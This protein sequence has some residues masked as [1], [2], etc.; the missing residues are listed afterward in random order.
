[1]T[2]AS[3]ERKVAQMAKVSQVAK[4]SQ[5]MK[6]P[7]MT[8]VERMTKVAQ[9]TKVSEMTKVAQKTKVGRMPKASQKSSGQQVSRHGQHEAKKCA[10]QNLPLQRW[11]G[12]TP[13]LAVASRHSPVLCSTYSTPPPPSG[14]ARRVKPQSRIDSLASRA[15][16]RHAL[17]AL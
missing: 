10:N 6:V 17:P 4:V 11:R 12:L 2:K 8:Q 1:M 3:H 13:K 9:K 15:L 5:T 16:S 14:A 7:Q